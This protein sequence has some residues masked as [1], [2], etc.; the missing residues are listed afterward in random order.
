VSVDEPGAGLAP[1]AVFAAEASVLLRAL[2][3]IRKTTRTILRM[4]EDEELG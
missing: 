2:R 1:L 4:G 3:A